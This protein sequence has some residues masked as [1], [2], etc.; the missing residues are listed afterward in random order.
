MAIAGNVW[1]FLS[2]WFAQ[3]LNKFNLKNAIRYVVI[4]KQCTWQSKIYQILSFPYGIWSKVLCII[5]LKVMTAW[6]RGFSTV[7]RILSA[8]F[9]LTFNVIWF[10]R[11]ECQDYV[12]DSQRFVIISTTRNCKDSDQGWDPPSCMKIVEL[13]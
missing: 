8:F 6:L 7:I 13:M 11:L 3:F 4:P 2:S 10:L 1:K 5:W 9:R 12:L